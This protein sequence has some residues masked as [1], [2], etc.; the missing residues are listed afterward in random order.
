MNFLR[1]WGS[2]A[3]LCLMAVLLAGCPNSCTRKETPPA[4]PRPPSAPQ[5]STYSKPVDPLAGWDAK[6]LAA[7][8][9]EEEAANQND[10]LA[11]LEAQKDET[12]ARMN[13]SDAEKAILQIGLKQ[14]KAGIAAEKLARQQDKLYWFAVIL[15]FVGLGGVALAIFSAPARKLGAGIAAGA[16]ALAGVVIFFA[17]YVLPWLPYIG[18]V[19][20]VI[21]VGAGIWYLR[22]KDKAV[23][24]RDK[25]T[26]QLAKGIDAAK[27]TIPAFGDGYKKVLGGHMDDDVDV[28]MDKVRAKLGLK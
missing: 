16:W 15:G 8:K 2:V 20:G 28:L 9:A 18:G 24:L 5:S 14:E 12:E 3:L 19:L 10:R 13:R 27:A 26:E 22:N 4:P 17:E 21:I 1:R 25:A 6:I 11:L 23:A 7:Q